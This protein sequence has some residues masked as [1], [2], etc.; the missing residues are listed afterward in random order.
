MLL[1]DKI[2][3]ETYD[4]KYNELA[5]KINQEKGE[6]SLYSSNVDVQKRVS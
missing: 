1:D 2:I 6:R 3:K 4:A 5:R